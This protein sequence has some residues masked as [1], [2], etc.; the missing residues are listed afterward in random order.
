MRYELYY[1]PTIQGRGEF[2]RLA[3]EE[4]AADYVDVARQ[5]GGQDKML[6]VMEAHSVKTPPFAPPFLRAG[7]LWIAQTADIL[8]YLGRR[9]DL[10]QRNEAGELWVHQLQLTVADFLVEVHDTHHPIGSGLYYEEQK[11]EAKRRADDFRANRAPKFLRYFDDVLRR[12]KGPYLTGR[13]LTYADLSLFQVIEGLRF[14]FPKAA[15]KLEK[16]H[17]RL[18][19][20]RDRVAARPRI[21][22]YLASPRRIPFN[23]HGIFRSYSELDG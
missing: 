23:Q 21:A 11:T 1:W 12:S 7:K 17:S 13:K 6:R 18:S 9:H 20:L 3:L 19:S 4:A 22:A 8:L 2:V 10:A 16:S 14:A 15:A 5:K